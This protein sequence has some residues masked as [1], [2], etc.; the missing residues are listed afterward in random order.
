MGEDMKKRDSKYESLRLIAMLFIVLCHYSANVR[1]NN[2][3]NVQKMMHEQFIPLGQIGVYL[4]VLISAYFLSQRRTNLKKSINRV[5]PLWIKTIFYSWLFIGL[6]LIFKFKPIKL[7]DL[8]ISAFPVS[9]NNYWFMTCFILLMLLL[10]VLNWMIQELDKKDLQF[11][12]CLLILFTAIIPIIKTNNAP[13]GGPWSTSMLGIVYLLGG[14]I[15]K[16]KV[17]LKIYFSVLMITIGLIGEYASMFLL[18]NND[19]SDA[20]HSMTRF[21]YGIFPLLV[22]LGIFILVLKSKSFYNPTIN[23]LA[24]NVLAAYLIADNV[25]FKD[26]LWNKLLHLNSYGNS[27]IQYTVAGVLVAIIL[28]IVCCLVDKIYD[29]IFKR[30]RSSLKR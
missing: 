9:L 24:T 23:F 17:N 30:I 3:T 16:Y 13:F 15:K 6:N 4:F 14:Y 22:A 19:S 20:L 5:V 21:S 11:Y 27:Y 8:L 29:C 26:F 18:K 7:S 1:W 10:P 25:F 12:L 28:V 2:T